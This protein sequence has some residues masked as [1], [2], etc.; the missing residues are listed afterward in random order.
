MNLERG[1]ERRVGS[2]VDDGNCD[3]CEDYKDNE[4]GHDGNC[5]WQCC[6]GDTD[7]RTSRT[8]GVV[9]CGDDCCNCKNENADDCEKYY[10][11]CS[12][13]HNVLVIR[14]RH[15]VHNIIITITGMTVGKQLG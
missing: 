14:K 13:D 8:V 15:D 9:W 11:D 7:G 3:G 10:C 5:I 12:T 1:L 2:D 4:D 6:C